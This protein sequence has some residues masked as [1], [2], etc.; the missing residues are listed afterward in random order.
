MNKM[1]IECKLQLTSGSAF[2]KFSYAL[3][4]CI[5]SPI[6]TIL[7]FAGDFIKD[8]MKSKLIMAG[9]GIEV[10][11]FEE[12]EGQFIL[13]DNRNL[14]KQRCYIEL[15]L[16]WFPFATGNKIEQQLKELGYE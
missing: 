6:P 4:D 16:N 12:D 15:G 13:I 3:D 10:E 2:E 7:V 11:F 1:A 9:H 5:A 8:D 14:L